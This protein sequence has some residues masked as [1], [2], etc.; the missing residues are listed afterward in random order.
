MAKTLTTPA[1]QTSQIVSDGASG[2]IISLSVS[3]GGSAYVQSSPVDGPQVWTTWTVGVVSGGVSSD[4]L[5]SAQLLRVICNAGTATLSVSDPDVR[6]VLNKLGNNFVWGANAVGPQYATDASGNVVGFSGI[7]LA[8]SRSNI[9]LIGMGHSGNNAGGSTTAVQAYTWQQMVS[10]RSR[11]MAARV[12]Y[13]NE[14][15]ITYVVDKTSITPS[16]TFPTSS[17]YDPTGGITPVNVTFNGSAPAVVLAGTPAA[18]SETLSDWMYVAGQDRSD[19]SGAFDQWAIR[20]YIANANGKVNTATLAGGSG[21][22]TNGIYTNVA[23]TGGTGAGATANITV[24]AGAVTAVA[25]LNPGNGFTVNDVLTTANTNLG[26]TGTG[27]TYTVTAVSNAVNYPYNTIGNYATYTGNTV[28]GRSWRT[29]FMSGD[30][31]ASPSGFTDNSGIALFM[32]VEFKE[33]AR[34]IRIVSLG[35]SLTGLSG[36]ADSNGGQFNT[37]TDQAVATMNASSTS[38]GTLWSNLNCGQT[39]QTLPGFIGRLQQILTNHQPDIVVLPVWS[40]NT[41]PTTAAALATNNGLVLDAI[42]R[43]LSSGAIPL[44]WTSPPQNSTTAAIDALRISNNTYW[45]K[46]A[47]ASGY[48]LADFASVM[49]GTPISSVTQWASNYSSDGT[50]WGVAGQAAAAQILAAALRMIVAA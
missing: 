5:M 36:V 11:A 1:G 23:L 49:D 16:T 37:V 30:K 43:I 19:V 50:H 29:G 41:S 31:I 3:A 9:E 24:Y 33:F 47:T 8:Q 44:L 34:H 26:G 42:N 13:V 12:S 28:S 10:A 48:I 40:P 32:N 46:V 25:I 20:S 4:T 17:P 18:P 27:F 35:D 2:S 7:R 21:Y 22:L 6:N 39:S 15:A 38:N 45:R 14:T